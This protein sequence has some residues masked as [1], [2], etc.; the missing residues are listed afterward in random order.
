MSVRKSKI[1]RREFLRVVGA[2][3][4]IS[5]SQAIGRDKSGSPGVAVRL[6]R[7]STGS[8]IWQVTTEQFRQSNIYCELPYC[9]GD[10]RHFIY[11][12]YD[13]NLS[14]KNKTELMV[15]EL[16]TWKQ[17]RLDVAWRLTGSAITGNGTFYYLKQTGEDV[18]GLMRADLSKGTMEEI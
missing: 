12:R 6:E 7:Q 2:G 11:E 9:S 16:G 14:G 1:C 15:V 5:A 10:C 3:A 8:E 18:L 4:L 17:R 13:P